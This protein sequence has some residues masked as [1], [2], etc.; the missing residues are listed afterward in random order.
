MADEEEVTFGRDFDFRA[1]KGHIR[2]YP[3][4]ATLSVPKAVADAARA[5]GAL[6]APVAPQAPIVAAPEPD[7]GADPA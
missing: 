7:P 3:A 4:G 2:A 5:A 6:Q 1:A